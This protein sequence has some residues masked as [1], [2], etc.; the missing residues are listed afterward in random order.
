[1]FALWKLTPIFQGEEWMNYALRFSLWFTSICVKFVHCGNIILSYPQILYLRHE[2][3]GNPTSS[4]H[5][6]VLSITK[7]TQLIVAIRSWVTQNLF[8]HGTI[9]IGNLWRPQAV[10]YG[11]PPKIIAHTPLVWNMSAIIIFFALSSFPI[12]R[13]PSSPPLSIILCHK[14]FSRSHLWYFFISW[15]FQLYNHEKTTGNRQWTLFV[16]F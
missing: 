16:V 14:Q 10:W 12:R 7:C 15:P 11:T 6:D 4:L 5:I 13:L 2:T 8:S 3:S 1:M 9:L